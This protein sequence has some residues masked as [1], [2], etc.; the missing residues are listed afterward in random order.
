MKKPYYNLNVMIFPDGD[1]FAFSVV[2]EFDEVGKDSE[3]LTSGS[4]E[5]LGWAL[6]SVRVA[7]NEA[8][9]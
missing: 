9:Q 6:A 7:V 5:T 3:V 4:G 1:E 2:Q 8:L